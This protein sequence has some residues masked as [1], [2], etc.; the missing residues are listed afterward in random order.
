MGLSGVG[1]TE[2]LLILVI[3]VLVFG[4]KKLGTLGSD[5]GAAIH[6]F[7]KAMS[8]DTPATPQESAPPE[9][10]AQPTPVLPPASTATAATPQ[11]ASRT[12]D[13]GHR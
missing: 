7:R 8:G 5:L 12:N 3:V 2:I 10:A 13:P 11:E 6:G 1:F 9:Q 4:T